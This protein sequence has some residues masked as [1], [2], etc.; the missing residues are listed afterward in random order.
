MGERSVEAIS[1]ETSP[2]KKELSTGNKLRDALRIGKLEAGDGG[3]L[4]KNEGNVEAKA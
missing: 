1:D 4:L 3:R 2:A